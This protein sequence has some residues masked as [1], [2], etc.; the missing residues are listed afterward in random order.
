M[1]LALEPNTTYN[2]INYFG[3]CAPTCGNARVCGAL[4]RFETPREHP[5]AS[6]EH[7]CPH[8]CQPRLSCLPEEN[9]LLHKK[10]DIYF[11][12]QPALPS[13][14][15]KPASIIVPP[16]PP[17]VFV[18]YDAC[19]TTIQQNET[20]QKRSEL[21]KSPPRRHKAA[22]LFVPRISRAE[23]RDHH[24]RPR[25][26]QGADR[27]VLDRCT[28]SV[29]RAHPTSL[30]LHHPDHHESLGLLH[31]TGVAGPAGKRQHQARC[32]SSLRQ[33]SGELI[34]PSVDCGQML[35]LCRSC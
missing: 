5:M 18:T 16:P 17:P 10:Y 27:Q 31:R 4:R 21:G 32:P 29:R 9:W 2:S 15:L 8:Q 14:L 12:Q 3:F 33:S 22:L 1:L 6:Q 25:G 23:D 28:W 20:F 11:K 19:T 26:T 30:R 7:S 34:G 24:R 13:A 35:M